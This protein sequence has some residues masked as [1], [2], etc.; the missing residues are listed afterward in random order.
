MKNPSDDR[1][2]DMKL[3]LYIDESP[4]NHRRVKRAVSYSLLQFFNFHFF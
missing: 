4:V 1:F 3:S 2:S